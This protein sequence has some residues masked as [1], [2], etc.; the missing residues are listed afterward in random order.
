MK[1][2]ISHYNG[3][4][5]KWRRLHKKELYVL[6]SLPNIIQVMKSRR[7]RW[8]GHVA[9]MRKRRS[10]YGVLVGKPEWRRPL[11]RPRRRWEDNIKIDHKEVG[12]GNGL[13]QSGSGQGY[14]VG[15]CECGNEHSS[16]IKCGEFL[17]APVSLSG[18]TLLDE[19]SYLT[20]TQNIS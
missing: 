7:L 8:T 5:R 17:R 15:C 14:V 20:T 11:G 19:I 4:L 10:A 2:I 1:L 6:H 13:D 18:R 16:S 9:R 12:G 3:V